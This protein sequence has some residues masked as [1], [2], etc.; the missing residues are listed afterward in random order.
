MWWLDDGGRWLRDDDARSR[1]FGIFH[2][3]RSVLLQESS[4]WWRGHCNLLYQKGIAKR[5]VHFTVIMAALGV[6]TLRYKKKFDSAD[7][8][9]SPYQSSKLRSWVVEFVLQNY[10]TYCSVVQHLLSSLFLIQPCRE[11]LELNFSSVSLNLQGLARVQN[12]AGKLLKNR[13][14]ENNSLKFGPLWKFEGTLMSIDVL[15]RMTAL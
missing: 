1:T 9:N 11:G 10:R 2:M 13:G 5:M 6:V 4:E 14:C 8:I 12:N 3:N 7:S 15:S